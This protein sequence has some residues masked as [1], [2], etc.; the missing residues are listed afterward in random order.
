[1]VAAYENPSTLCSNTTT[2]FCYTK[3]GLLQLSAWGNMRTVA[4]AALVAMAHAS[5]SSSLTDAARRKHRCFA[6]GQLR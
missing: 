5:A 3:S 4:N 1:M 6:R 2:T